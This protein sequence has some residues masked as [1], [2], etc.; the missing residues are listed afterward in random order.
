MTESIFWGAVLRV[1]Q[2]VSQAAPFILIGFI[3]AAVFR[4]WLGPQS[5]RKL[6]G[7]GTWRSLPQAWALGMLLPVCSLGVI[8]VMREMKRAG[9]RGGTILAFGLT[10][11]LFN[12][13]SVLYGLTLSE[14]FTIFAFSICSLVVVT[15]IGLL[16][17]WAFPA[18]VFQEDAEESVP[19]GIKRI[20][21]V[22]VSMGKEFW[23]YS[24][25]YIL[26]GLSGIVFLNVILPKASFQ[27]SVN[28]GDLWAP[29]LMTGVAV[30]AYATPML[31]MS[32][33]GTMFQHGNSVGAAFALLIL[34]AGLNFG[35]I[36]WMVV[37]YGWKKSI[38][39]MVVLLLVVLG[40][41]YGL[42]KPLYPTDIDPADHSHA[43]D[44]YCCPF[45]VDQS[46]LPAAVWQKLEDDVRTEETFGMISLFVIAASGLIFLAVDR[47]FNLEKWLTNSPEITDE[48][49]RNMDVVLP[50]WVLASAAIIGLVV[51]SVAMCFAYYP[52]PEECLEEIFIVKGE[53]L[54]AARSSHNPHAMHWIP[55]WEDWNR[56][57][58]VGV[59]LR[60]FQLS[61]YHRMKARVVADYIELLEHAIEDNDREEVKQFATLLAR[62]HSRMVKAYQTVSKESAE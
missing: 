46:H 23:S 8:P 20:L 40:L 51:V 37:A 28:G 39:W 49:S 14:P 25:V 53:V 11:P 31:A 60:E 16:F 52:S 33:L 3:I 57:L 1:A 38:C 22:F 10:A 5:V 13:L 54:S 29:I 7:E 59:Y 2:S 62:A 6:F 12:P 26:I 34:G 61:D 27:T 42:E 41:G 43:F 50:N 48:K 47:R 32:Q 9:L 4:R 30:P 56:R 24:T 35:I 19:Y 18:A 45:S 58:Q 55:V 21:S 36:V 44:V 17:D 15:C